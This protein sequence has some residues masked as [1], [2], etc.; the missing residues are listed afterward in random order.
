ML[1]KLPYFLSKRLDSY[2]K[3]RVLSKGGLVR[4]NVMGHDMILDIR[5]GHGWMLSKGDQYEAQTTKYIVDSVKEGS[6]VV[7]VG[8]SMGYYTLLLARLV[9]PRGRVY[10]FEPIPRDFAILRRNVNANGYR[11]VVLENKAVSDTDGIARF[12]ISPESYGMSSLCPLTNPESIIQVEV[13]CL[14]NYIHEDVDLIKVDVEGAEHLVV[15]GSK[16]LIQKS[17]D[18]HLIVEF[19]PGRFGFDAN[20]LFSELEGWKYRTLDLNLLFWKDGKE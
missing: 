4:S 2:L 17:P 9:G 18:P 20:Q 11:N 7:D 16:E 13:V 1:P 14:D 10:A 15:K 12:Y 8:A 5:A 6:V 3:Q 19:V